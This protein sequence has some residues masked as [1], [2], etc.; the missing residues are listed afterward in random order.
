MAD[1][2]CPTS[3]GGRGAP[4]REAEGGEVGKD[5][6]FVRRAGERRRTLDNTDEDGEVEQEVGTSSLTRARGGDVK[7]AGCW[8]LDAGR[9]CISS[10][11]SFQHQHASV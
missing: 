8:T 10:S 1:T 4:E 5:K 3:S 9:Q 2:R 6:I 11:I 7:D